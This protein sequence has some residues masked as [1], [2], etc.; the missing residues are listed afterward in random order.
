MGRFQQ[1]VHK[2]VENFF[3]GVIWT[4]SLAATKPH[5]LVPLLHGVFKQRMEKGVT[6]SAISL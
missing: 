2:A 4:V 1:G 5:P 3:P 6:S